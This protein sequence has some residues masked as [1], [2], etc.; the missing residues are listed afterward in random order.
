MV[1]L[2]EPVDQDRSHLWQ[3]AA[4]GNFPEIVLSNVLDVLHVSHVGVDFVDIFDDKLRVLCIV[5]V[6]IFNGT[7]VLRREG[8]HDVVDI[9]HFNVPIL[10]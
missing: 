1:H 8:G 10:L 2:N 6:D 5:S 3:D 7:K 4:P 9:F